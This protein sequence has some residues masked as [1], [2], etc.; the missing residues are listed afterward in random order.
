MY[1]T[2]PKQGINLELSV[3]KLAMIGLGLVLLQLTG[4]V[5]IALN[6]IMYARDPKQVRFSQN[7]QDAYLLIA[8]AP[9]RVPYILHI[10]PYDEAKQQLEFGDLSDDMVIKVDSSNDPTYL[11]KRVKPGKYIFVALFDQFHWGACFNK[12]TLSFT[13]NAND[14]VFLGNYQSSIN[15][16]QIEQIAKSK[17]QTVAVGLG[18][19][20]YYDDILPPQ[21]SKPS[22]D[23][24]DFQLAKTYEATSLPMLNGRLQP[25]IYKSAKFTTGSDLAGNPN[26]LAAP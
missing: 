15:T 6:I 20:I 21:I 3:K 9:T 14:A 24:A 23:N 19:F 17:G 13:V 8:L 11:A 10:R 18:Q 2:P 4:C 7:D 16:T 12:N 22:V 1:K 26:C 5:G 25:V